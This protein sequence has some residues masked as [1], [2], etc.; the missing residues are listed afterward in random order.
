MILSGEP[1]WASWDL[2][3]SDLGSSERGD[4]ETDTNLPSGFIE[5]TTRRLHRF[6]V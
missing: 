5:V 2:T 6:G 3:A 1:N 4:F